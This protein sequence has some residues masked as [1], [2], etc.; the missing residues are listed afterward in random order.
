[1]NWAELKIGVYV[2]AKYAKQTY[3]KEC[4]DVRLNAGMAMVCDILK[5]AG[6]TNIDYC[7]SATAHRFDMVMYSVTSDCDWWNFVAERVTW[8]PGRYK[9]CVGGQGVLNPRPFLELVDYFVLGRAEGVQDKLAEAIMLGEEPDDCHIVSS[10]TYS[11]DKIY[12]INQ[13]EQIYPHDIVLDNGKT[14]HEDVIGCNHRCLFC[15]YTWHR[16]Q[17]VQEAFNYSGLWNGGADRERAMIDMHRGIEVDLVK[18]RT[19]AID[20]LSERLRMMVNKRITREMLREFLERLASCEK[21]HQVKFYNIIGYPTETVDDWQEFLQ[22]IVQTD[23]KFTKQA[24][25]TSILLHSTP[26][27]AMPATPLACAEMSLTNY[28]GLIARRLG[29]GKYKGN[30]FYQGNA[31]W[32]VE[33]MATESLATVM[34][35]AIIWRGTEDDTENIVK[36]A[37]NKK[38]ETASS[39]IKQATLEKYFDVVKLFGRFT[40]ETLPTRNIRTYC[41]VEK[42]WR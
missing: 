36:I 2:L 15:G 39:A 28:R 19:T 14:Y 20:G 40:P 24:K 6:F 42:M 11:I 38:F 29:G 3:S 7:S 22:D 12:R 31:M 5:R 41:A 9:V 23:A 25:Q 17:A 18:L 26:F 8:K 37:T 10:K 32:A 16:R 33:S 1:M 34:Q 27:R 30:I 13:V 21:P 35:S 4:Y